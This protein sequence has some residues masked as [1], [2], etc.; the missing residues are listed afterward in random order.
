MAF[1]VVMAAHYVAASVPSEKYDA[2]VVTESTK[3]SD[4]IRK[5]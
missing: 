2:R 1:V 5:S 4:N 3:S